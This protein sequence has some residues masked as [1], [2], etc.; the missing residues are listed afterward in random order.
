MLRRFTSLIIRCDLSNSTFGCP[1]VRNIIIGSGTCENEVCNTSFPISANLSPV[2][3]PLIMFVTETHETACIL[4]II[5]KLS[6]LY[7]QKLSYRLG[8]SRLHSEIYA[9][10]WEICP[11]QTAR[12][13]SHWFYKTI[14]NI[15]IH[16]IVAAV[17][18]QFS[19]NLVYLIP[20]CN[21]LGM[22][23]T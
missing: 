5:S 4:Y 7:F 13:L 9:W 17:F 11:I 14:H 23:I 16:T 10:E 1:S 20:F 2:L 19:S 6:S 3:K 8:S 21:I 15:F 22:V 18:V 12:R